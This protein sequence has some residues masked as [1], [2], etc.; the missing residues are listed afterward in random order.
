VVPNARSNVRLKIVGILITDISPK[1]SLSAPRCKQVET[2]ILYA[3]NTIPA[4]D[5]LSENY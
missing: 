5:G 4:R 1:V 2:K 3:L